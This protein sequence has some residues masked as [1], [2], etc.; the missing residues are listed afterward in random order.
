M[1]IEGTLTNLNAALNGLSLT[2]ASKTGTVTLAYFDLGNKLSGTAV[3][4]VSQSGGV[5]TGP[6]PLALT[7][8]TTNSLVSSTPPDAQT[9]DLGFAAAVEMLVG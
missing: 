3:I 4:N 7:S 6:G 9:Q 5:S 2:L 8:G 1:L